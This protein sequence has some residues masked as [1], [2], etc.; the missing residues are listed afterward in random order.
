VNEEN[1]KRINWIKK[2]KRVIIKLGSG[3]LA[4]RDSGLDKT[5]F[6]SI[7]ADVATIRKMDIEVVLVS[8]GAV[9]AGMQKLGMH[10]RPKTLIDKQTAAAVGQTQLLWM[11]ENSFSRYGQKVAQILLTH[12]DMVDRQRF[13]NARHTIHSLL[14]WGVIPIINENDTVA[15]DEIKFGDNDELSSLVVNLTDSPLLIILS[16]VDG[17]FDI[18]PKKNKNAKLLPYIDDASALLSAGGLESDGMTG[19]G[20]MFSK[21]HAS[22]TASTLGAATVIANGKTESV[23]SK[24]MLGE[25][26]GTFF[27][28]KES[29]MVSRKHWIAYAL[30]QKGVITADEGAVM[31][32]SKNG[33]SLLPSGIVSVSGEFEAGEMVSCVNLCGSE[34]ARGIT[35]FSS[36]D[37]GKIK[38]ARTEEV[39]SILGCSP[40]N[41]VIHRDDLV[42]MRDV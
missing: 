41:E 8:S 17:V 3:T 40:C 38:G 9:V 27:A 20:G 5:V 25:K 29:R 1:Y 32:V 4:R 28:P 35:S 7:A 10:R 2:A 12:D 22:K 33:K 42:L 18:N 34:F 26:I 39:Y 23:L 36:Q 31:A 11:Y 13:I 30:K 24:I 21:L 6:E 15:V 14:E 37:I 19:T 16:D